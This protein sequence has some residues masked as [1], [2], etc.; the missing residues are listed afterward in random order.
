MRL[1]NE[2]TLHLDL[3]CTEIAITLLDCAIASGC[4]DSARLL[5]DADVGSNCPW[6][7]QFGTE[8]F[9]PD[10]SNIVVEASKERL[11]HLVEFSKQNLPAQIFA[12]YKLYVT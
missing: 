12:S 8:M 3:E 1:A 2:S 4:T 10:I 9:S 5:L 11:E 7:E 6:H